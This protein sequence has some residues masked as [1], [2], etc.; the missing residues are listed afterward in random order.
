MLIIYGP[1]ER[2]WTT[3][4]G[5]L[6]TMGGFMLSCNGRL[7]HPLSDFMISELIKLDYIDISITEK[8][9]ADKSKGDGLSKGLVVLQTTW[10]AMQCIARGVQH[11]PITELEF[12]T[13]AFVTLN[14]TTYVLWWHKPFNVQSAVPV[15]LKRMINDEDWRTIQLSVNIWN[16]RPPAVSGEPIQDGGTVEV[17]VDEKQT[18]DQHDGQGVVGKVLR[19]IQRW[20]Q[21]IGRFATGTQDDNVDLSIAERVPTLY[22][23]VLGY[24][25]DRNSNLLF[26]AVGMVFGVIHCIA[27]SYSFPSHVEQILWRVSCIVIMGVPRAYL[28][29]Y[30]VAALFLPAR[31]IP[32]ILRPLL[33]IVIPPLLFVYFIGRIALFVLAFMSLR[34]LPPGAYKTIHWTTFIPHI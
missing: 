21:L 9:I 3:S 23:G 13:L 27:W 7:H 32:S 15:V 29:M 17:K 20:I 34:A 11:L 8:E 19:P 31:Q 25:E 12:V 33:K 1:K 22:A 10:F 18:V 24:S 16:Q 5:F 4:H 2:E 26:A 6:T 30:I 28:V 14:L